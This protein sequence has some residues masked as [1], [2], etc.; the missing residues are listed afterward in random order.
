MERSRAA[1]LV[2]GDPPLFL[3]LIAHRVRWRLLRELVYSDR[4]VWEL[5]QLLGERQSLVSYHLRQLRAEGLVSM[6][7][8]SADRRDSYYT[9][10]LLRCGE[11]LQAAG[12]A[13]H[14]GLCLVPASPAV[15]RP[16][17]RRRPKKRV[18]FLCT[19]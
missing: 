19:G 8:S 6:R 7:R 16:N 9:V 18:L 12:G 3:G 10:D 11:L 15:R 14:P 1:R 13:L 2:D 5:T 4:A 17:G